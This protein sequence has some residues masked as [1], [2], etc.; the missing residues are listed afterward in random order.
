MQKLKSIYYKLFPPKN[1]RR[2]SVSVALTT[3]TG[4]IMSGTTLSSSVEMKNRDEEAPPVEE[5][6][7][8]D[9]DELDNI[10]A[11]VYDDDTLDDMILDSK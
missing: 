5:D 9:E 11:P 8:D 3:D 7:E 2:Q 1:P 10:E 6:N 4:S